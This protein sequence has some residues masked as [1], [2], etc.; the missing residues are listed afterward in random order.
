[1][2]KNNNTIEDYPREFWINAIAQWIKD[3]KARYCLVRNY[4]DRIPYETI[5]EELNI[6][7]STVYRKIS[8]YEKILFN[9]I[10]E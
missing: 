7:R 2:R 6:S 4:L 5:A 10:N 1:M 8:K 3:E 9:N